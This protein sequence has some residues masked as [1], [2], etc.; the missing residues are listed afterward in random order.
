MT[1]ERHRDLLRGEDEAPGGVDNEVDRHLRR[2]EPDR[3]ENLLRVVDVNVA[4]E[5]DTEKRNPLLA[6]DEGDDPGTSF[7]LQAPD[8][9]QAAGPG[10]LLL[11]DRHREEEEDDGDQQHGPDIGHAPR[12]L[13][14]P[15]VKNVRTAGPSSGREELVDRGLP[16]AAVLKPREPD[17]EEPDLGAVEE[18]EE[19]IARG[20][21]D[22]LRVRGEPV[23]CQ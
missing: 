10:H 8:R 2:G 16:G 11:D 3:P 15:R 7:H 19:E 1:L 12:H 13:C 22:N 17:P 14:A 9:P 4:I 21:P 5:R 20:P 6:V 23:Q 18:R